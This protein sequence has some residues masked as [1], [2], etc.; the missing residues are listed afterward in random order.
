M[1]IRLSYV[2]NTGRV[3][4]LNQD[5]LLVGHE[6]VTMTSMPAPRAMELTAATA[7]FVVADGMGG[8]SLGEVAA[9]ETLAVLQAHLAAP[10]TAATFPTVAHAARERLDDL[11]REKNLRLGTTLAGLVISPAECFVFNVGDCR[12]YK[13]RA[14]FL[15]R[16]TKDHSLLEMAIS[17]GADPKSIAKNVVTSAIMGGDSGEMEIFTKVLTC[18]PGDRFLVCCDGLWGALAVEDMEAGLQAGEPSAVVAHLLAAALP[19]S[20]DNISAIFVEIA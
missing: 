2:T 15:N 11:A 14:G 12:V 3:R 20:D 5:A 10:C 19:T 1:K 18:R 8:E 6:L 16:L 4:S 13:V 9:A 7:W 17:S